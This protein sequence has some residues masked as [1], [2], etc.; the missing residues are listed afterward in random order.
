[1][2]VLNLRM[3]HDRFLFQG[4]FLFLIKYYVIALPSVL[5][6]VYLANNL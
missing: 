4:R 3:N 6:V 2:A 1:M 5:R